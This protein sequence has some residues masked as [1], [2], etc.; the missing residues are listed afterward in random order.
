MANGF[1]RRGPSPLTSKR[2]LYV[3]LM[4]QGLSNSEACRRVGVNRK[5]GCRWLYGRTTHDKNPYY[6]QPIVTAAKEASTRYLSQHERIVIADGKR[7]GRSARS[8]ASELGRTPSTVSRELAR[9]ATIGGDYRPHVAHQTMLTRRPRPRL[10]RVESNGELRALIQDRLDKFWSPEQISKHMRTE[11]PDRPE[12]WLA[13]ESLYQALYGPSNVLHRDQQKVL[14]TGRGHRRRRVVGQRRARFV[15]PM[16][17]ITDR[18]V[19]ADDRQVVGH[20]EG[21]LIT[22]TQNKSAIGTLVER[23][24]GF[25]ILVHFDGRHDAEQLR[26]SMTEVFKN[27]PDGLRRSVTWDQGIEMARHH[28][29]SAATSVPVFF[30]DAH[31]PWQRGTNENTNGLLR[32][33]FPKGTDLSKYTPTD[34]QRVADELNDR[35]RKRLAWKTPAELFATLKTEAA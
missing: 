14:R 6:Y 16:K 7:A 27:L 34:L 29:F 2:D 1:G 10:R 21:D 17:P 5:T 8:I 19:E 9:N 28:E 18:P 3:Q 26:D 11:F 24:T 20:W 35:P 31:S 4:R 12:L 30:C 15:S 22:G 33:Y 25:T 32:Q 23:T 13:A